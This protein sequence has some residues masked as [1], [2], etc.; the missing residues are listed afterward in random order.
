MLRLSSKSDFELPSSQG[1]KEHPVSYIS[2]GV[3]KE[4]A[5][6]LSGGGALSDAWLVS[7]AS[8]HRCTKGVP[9]AASHFTCGQK[10]KKG[11][12]KATGR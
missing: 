10:L 1:K 12:W 5:H 8:L 3:R 7:P 6:Q 2:V 11:R 9:K 4:E